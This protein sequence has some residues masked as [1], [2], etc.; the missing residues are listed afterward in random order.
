[1]KIK[2]A[3]MGNQRERPRRVS[4]DQVTGFNEKYLIT[5]C[6]SSLEVQLAFLQGYSFSRDLSRKLSLFKYLCQMVRINARHI[7]CFFLDNT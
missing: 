1:M 7:I 5:R 4:A 3:E 6:V 2:L